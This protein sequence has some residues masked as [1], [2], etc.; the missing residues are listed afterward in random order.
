M[1]ASNIN[2]SAILGTTV[3]GLV[4]IP[5]TEELNQVPAF[6]ATIANTTENR[7]TVSANISSTLYIYRDNSEV[8]RGLINVDKIQYTQTK[9]IMSGYASHI[10]LHFVFFSKD[11]SQYDIR[12][13]QFDNIAANTILGYV[14]N[15][16]GYSVSEC[17]TTQISLRGE[18]ETK[19]QWIAAIAKACKYVSGS[20]TYS[21]DWWIETSGAV[22]I[23]QSRGSAKGVLNL[24]ETLEREL[25]YGYIQNTAYGLGYADGINQLQTV[26]SNAASISA[27]G[28]REIVKIDRRFQKQTAIDNEMQ[29]RADAHADPVETVPCEI[30]TWDWYNLNLEVGDTVTLE[31]ET[32]GIDGSYRIQ[33]ANIGVVYTQL[34]ITNIVPRLSSEI[35]A[36]R[37]QLHVDGGYMQGQT[38]PLNF[39]NMD[40][41]Q[42]GFPLKLNLHIPAKSKAINACYLSFDLEL[43][44]AFVATSADESSHTHAFVVQTYHWTD[45]VTALNGAIDDAVTTITVDSTSSFHTSG[46]LH[47]DDEQITYTG[48]T[49]TT[50]TGCTR[51]ANSTSAA[52]HTD[53][54][55]VDGESFIFGGFYDDLSIPAIKIG[56]QGQT[57]PIKSETTAA[58]STH[59]HAPQFGIME[60]SD[61][62]PSISIE[63]DSVDRTAALGGPW[64]TDQE[65]IDITTYIQTTGKHTI[66]LISTQ[67]ARITAEV[68]AQVF[69]QSD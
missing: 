58:G 41:V 68:W 15:G 30:A 63:I 18:Y 69:I 61:N 50:F 4:D 11:Q 59:T 64:A 10:D 13:V 39:S 38:V 56:G 55:V 52:S 21:C 9:I 49:A 45:V 1:S 42:S 2:Y 8:F 23:K 14:L 24:T 26:K 31:D 29:E 22:H 47:I 37:R 46:T 27:Y 65:E 60:D 44:R 67:R 7:E 3:I 48:K 16:T 57:S 34:N 66:E 32:T 28:V 5:I 62:S 53:N 20:N 43:Y 54:S 40:N 33:K 36:I 19:L 12:R 35:Q 51:G 6:T 25:D 17:P